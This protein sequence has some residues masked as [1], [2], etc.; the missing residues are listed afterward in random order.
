MNRQHVSRLDANSQRLAEW[1]LQ[2]GSELEREGLSEAGLAST[3]GMSEAEL[4]AALDRLEA[5]EFIVRM[6]HP[7]SGT[8]QM[9]LKAGRAWPEMREEVFK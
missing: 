4:N 7:S 2:R 6:P 8:M 3:L 1:L 9:M 5:R